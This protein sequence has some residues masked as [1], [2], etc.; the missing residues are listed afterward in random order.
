MNQNDELQFNPIKQG[1]MQTH[2]LPQGS[3][4]TIVEKN[5][6]L[7]EE[8]KKNTKKKKNKA[9]RIVVSVLVMYLLA[10][11]IIS[12]NA[13]EQKYG[14]DYSNSYRNGTDLI[15]P[16]EEKNKVPDGAYLEEFVDNLNPINLIDAAIETSKGKK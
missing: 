12:T 5:E 13:V 3:Y 9:F 2:K 6:Q 14:V 4:I 11:G 16:E 8:R 10:N 7:P 15:L 1:K